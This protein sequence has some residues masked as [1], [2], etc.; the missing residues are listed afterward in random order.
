VQKVIAL[1]ASREWYFM[2]TACG[3]PQGGGV[4][5]MRTNVGM[6]RGVNNLIFLYASYMDGPSK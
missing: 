1:V 2:S 5:L 4:S 6:G 3:R